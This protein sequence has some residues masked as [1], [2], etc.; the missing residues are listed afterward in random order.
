MISVAQIY[1]SKS[2]FSEYIWFGRRQKLINIKLEV[3]AI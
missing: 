2:L 3:K 1:E